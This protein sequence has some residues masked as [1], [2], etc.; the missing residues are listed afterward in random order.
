M[1]KYYQFEHN[2]PI[3]QLEIIK[4]QKKPSDHGHLCSSTLPHRTWTCTCVVGG[5]I[6]HLDP[7]LLYV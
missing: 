2:G 1:H 4:I 5:G 3:C 7:P 6:V